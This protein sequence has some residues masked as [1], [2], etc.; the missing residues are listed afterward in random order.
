MSGT[1]KIGHKDAKTG[2]MTS[3]VD[4]P[5]FGLG[6]YLMKGHGE[7]KKAVSHAIEYGYR[8]ID[9]AMAYG[10]ESEVGEAVRESEVTR[11]EIFVVTKLRRPHAISYD[12]VIRR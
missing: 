5:M 6:V 9:T 2:E 4:I 11:D 1:I 7:C 10:N 3:Q 8:L 12:E